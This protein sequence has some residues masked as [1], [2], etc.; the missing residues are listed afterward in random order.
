[1]MNC[2]C[3]VC[4]IDFFGKSSNE[5]HVDIFSEGGFLLDGDYFGGF[6]RRGD[7]FGGGVFRKGIFL[8]GGKI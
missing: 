6:F 2:K 5:M 1:M 7:L 4:K 8:G 3:M